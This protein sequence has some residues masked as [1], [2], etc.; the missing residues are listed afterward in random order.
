MKLLNPNFVE[1]PTYITRENVK[2]YAKDRFNMGTKKELSEIHRQ[3][4]DTEKLKNDTV[5]N[6]NEFKDNTKTNIENVSN[7]T[8][9]KFILF[10][11]KLFNKNKNKNEWL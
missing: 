1:A 6:I 2:K 4:W 7:A 10:K 11:K 3:K 5:D 8:K 9:T